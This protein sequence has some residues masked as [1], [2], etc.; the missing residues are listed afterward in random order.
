MPRALEVRRTSRIELEHHVC[1]RFQ[2]PAIVRDDHDP[3]VEGLQLPLEP[4]QALDVEMVGRLVEEEE[5]GIAAERPRQRCSRELASGER[6]ELTVELLVREAEAADDRG[7]ALAPVVA[8][9][10][11]EP[12]L[13][14][15]V[16]ANR[17]VVVIAGCHRPLEPPQ[18][19]LEG[20]QVTRA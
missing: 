7:C 1:H 2:K 10:M 6:V 13:G 17:R 3:G 18:L 16:P 9:G 5:I 11:L 4:F 19:F 15:A 20:D 12:R 8:A 14:L